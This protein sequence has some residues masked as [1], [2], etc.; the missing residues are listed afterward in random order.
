MLSL[1][2]IRGGA[3]RD[4][5]GSV[6]RSSTESL[7][8]KTLFSEQWTIES[9]SAQSFQD[10]DIPAE[11]ASYTTASVQ[12]VRE[13]E[14][15]VL[16]E[17][18]PPQHAPEYLHVI[19][20]ILDSIEE[21]HSLLGSVVEADLGTSNW[22]DEVDHS[23]DEEGQQQTPSSSVQTSPLEEDSKDEDGR[24]QTPSSVQTSPLEEN[25]PPLD[26]FQQTSNEVE[27]QESPHS[28]PSTSFEEDHTPQAAILK[29]PEEEE[30]QQQPQKSR[31]ARTSSSEQG[32]LTHTV[33]GVASNEEGHQRTPRSLRPNPVQK[34]FPLAR[35]GQPP[36]A[37]SGTTQTLVAKRA[38][39]KPVI[40]QR[41]VSQMTQFWS[42]KE[43]NLD[44]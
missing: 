18:S 23:K 35:A 30:E 6:P 22:A 3:R 44:A 33:A 26:A 38:S 8:K 13:S 25:Y 24:Q 21:E 34:R 16:E 40:G 43:T 31:S 11:S 41:K 36:I 20:E 1:M 15:A 4:S 14:E 42:Q 29:I 27:H 32:Y 9:P 37:R 12:T 7:S 2:K 39:L 17:P 19:P 10:Q 28:I 5:S